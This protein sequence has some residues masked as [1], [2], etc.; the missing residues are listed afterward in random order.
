MEK[1]TI[2]IR[3]LSHGQARAIEEYFAVWKFLNEKNMSMWCSFF[4]DCQGKFIPSI[5]VNGQEPK[6]FMKD[7]G[8][9]IG[10]V[11]FVSDNGEEE[12]DMYLLDYEKVEKALADTSTEEQESSDSE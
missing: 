10:K 1:V 4:V 11:K 6:R 5:Q 12:D 9:R 7:I 3:N 2:E 8:L